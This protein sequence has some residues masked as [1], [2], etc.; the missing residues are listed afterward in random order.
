MDIYEQNTWSILLLKKIAT[1]NNYIFL[2]V[3]CKQTK[4]DWS[5]QE[6][7]N[8]CGTKQKT[9]ISVTFKF[10]TYIQKE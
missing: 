7:K 4:K 2:F 1:K 10:Y 5:W 9:T 8:K 3:F 6:K